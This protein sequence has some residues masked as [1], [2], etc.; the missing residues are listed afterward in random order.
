MFRF[1]IFC[2]IA[3]L[4]LGSVAVA[5]EVPVFGVSVGQLYSG[6]LA[7]QSEGQ[8]RLILVHH[9]QMDANP[10]KIGSLVPNREFK[11]RAGHLRFGWPQ[12]A[13]YVVREN[14]TELLR[15]EPTYEPVS[16]TLKAGQELHVEFPR[17]YEPYDGRL[18]SVQAV[19]CCIILPR[20]YWY[21]DVAPGEFKGSEPYPNS[22]FFLADGGEWGFGEEKCLRDLAAFAAKTMKEK[23]P[24]ED[25]QEDFRLNHLCINIAL[26]PEGK[27]QPTLLALS[28]A[29]LAETLYQGLNTAWTEMKQYKVYRPFDGQNGAPIAALQEAGFL[30]ADWPADRTYISFAEAFELAKKGAAKWREDYPDR[31][32][33]K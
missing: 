23:N 13:A 27:I 31:A 19:Q 6:R 3:F 21:Q 17:H 26:S 33:K 2:L 18:F 15:T 12:H 5:Q 28:E 24:K 25:G 9:P 14:G 20:P 30:P 11:I 10:V 7:A 16:L 22:L 8:K 4:S 1:S 32:P 29:E